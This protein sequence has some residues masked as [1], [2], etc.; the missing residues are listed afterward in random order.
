MQKL[1]YL[2]NAYNL[3]KKVDSTSVRDSIKMTYVSILHIYD[4]LLAQIVKF[5]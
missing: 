2:I 1:K 3:S 5:Q 4:I